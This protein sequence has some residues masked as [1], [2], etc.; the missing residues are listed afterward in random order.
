MAFLQHSMQKLDAF[1]TSL[2]GWRKHL[3]LFLT[4]CLSALSM[5]PAYF[6]PI[7]FIT[8][9]VL[10]FI[11]KACTT[12]KQSFFT[13]WLFALG[14]FTAGLY[15][16]SF[17]LFV[18]FATWWWVTPFALFALPMA[19]S[20]FTGLATLL[21]W[22]MTKD[23]S[24]PLP[25]FYTLSLT[26]FLAELGRGYLFTGFPWN[27]WGYTWLGI[28]PMAQN[29]AWAGVY[30]LTGFTIMWAL[31]AALFAYKSKIPLISIFM[32]ML[33]FVY[34]QMRLIQHE[35]LEKHDKYHM[36]IVQP[37]IPQKEKWEKYK[38]WP[39][40]DKL[41][42][43]SSAPSKAP[44]T[45]II[46][47]ETALTISPEYNIE[48]KETISK[49][50]TERH[51]NALLMS[52][53]IRVDG[54]SFYNSFRIYNQTGLAQQSFDKAHLV[55]FGEYI[56]FR[57]W[58]NLSPIGSA[59]SGTADFSSGTGPYHAIYQNSPTFSPLIC[60]EV[61]FPHKSMPKDK[62]VD[63]LIN[64]TNDGWYGH[65]SGPY[66]HLGISQ[67]RA[68]ETGR[69]LIRAAGTGISAYIDPLGR[70]VHQAKLGQEK[71]IDFSIE[72]PI[73][74]SF[75][76]HIWF[77]LIYILALILTTIVCSIKAKTPNNHRFKSP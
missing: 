57:N 30:L 47:P 62:P 39:N 19:L 25:L 49:L 59:I 17:A 16:I 43:L 41:I 45:H 31:S 13:G 26:L 32:M 12:K 42:A 24:E 56:P 68:I 2:T 18:D 11:L 40:F 73:N 29:L 46:W 65:T 28:L 14:Y 10:F 33:C 6:F 35:T 52:G 7:L 9:P 22:R 1:C 61:L 34:G 71:I 69:P 5:A 51:P 38:Q 60:Y 37:N 50:L 72:K 21:A 55:P 36:R 23:I 48:V 58:I 3:F 8:L 75:N 20:I 67:A 27:L 70:V 53:N 64:A 76:I 74:T 63:L 4:G 77:I 66:Q 54:Q 15:W 44:L